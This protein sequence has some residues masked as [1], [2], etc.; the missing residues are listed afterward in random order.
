MNK[1]IFTALLLISILSGCA[2]TDSYYGARTSFDVD[3]S[4]VNES[5]YFKYALRFSL[6]YKQRVHLVKKIAD[7]EYKRNDFSQKLKSGGANAVVI[8]STGTSNFSATGQALGLGLSVVDS[9]LEGR[10]EHDRFATLTMNDEWLGQ[11]DLSAEEA[12]KLS[13]TKTTNSLF[14]TAKKFGFDVECLAN[15]GTHMATYLLVSNKNNSNPKE[16]A[17][18]KLIAIFGLEGSLSE[19][20]SFPEDSSPQMK[21]V[22]GDKARFFAKKWHILIGEPYLDKS[23]NVTHELLPL[24]NKQHYGV[25]TYYNARYKDLL[26]TPLGRDM[27]RDLS[28]RIDGWVYYNSTSSSM[29]FALLDGNIYKVSGQSQMVKLKGYMTT[30]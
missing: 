10:S 2:S 22:Y 14:A 21:S 28:S 25:T 20:D 13:V 8:A 6:P 12:F 3:T 11:D 7:S 27:Y 16:Y 24:K 5:V 29:D 1:H 23:N 9:Y 30:N 17:P 4:K 26:A 19:D 18:K 15:C